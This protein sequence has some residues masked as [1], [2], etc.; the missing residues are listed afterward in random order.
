MK[1]NADLHN[2]FST[3]EN[4]GD[5]FNKAINRAK[6]NL[7]ENG[8][9]AVINAQDKGLGRYETFLGLRGYKRVDLGNSLYVPEQEIYVI[10]GQ[11]VFTQ[12]GHILV[13]GLD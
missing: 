10:K 8:I 2:H 5:C 1:V 13:L 7:K 11:E 9:F 12:G 6:R 3:F 4:I